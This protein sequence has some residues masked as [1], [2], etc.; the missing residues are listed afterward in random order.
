[1]PM[2]GFKSISISNK[3][4]AEIEKMAKKDARSIPK[5]IE[6]MIPIIKKYRTLT[7]EKNHTAIKKITPN[8]NPQNNPKLHQKT[9]KKEK[10]PHPAAPTKTS[11]PSRLNNKNNSLEECNTH[12]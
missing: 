2:E 1:M 7:K 3:T 8:N 11:N 6:Y 5:Q 10:H 9:L 12:E 4:Y